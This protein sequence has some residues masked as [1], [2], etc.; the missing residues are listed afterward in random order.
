LTRASNWLASS[1]EIM[2][3]V[4]QWGGTGVFLGG[5]IAL[6]VHTQHSDASRRKAFRGPALSGSAEILS[7]A[8]EGGLKPV[9]T[10]NG[11]RGVLCRI[12]LRV[13]LP[14]RAP[15]DATVSTSVE[16]GVLVDLCVDGQRW[17]VD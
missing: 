9:F 12:G 8:R 13:Q 15:Y 5:L 6:F 7:A 14:G 2:W 1:A 3:H 16:S 10:S 17:E 4:F 11:Y